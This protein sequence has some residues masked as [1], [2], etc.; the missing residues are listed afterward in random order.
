MCSSDLMAADKIVAQPS[1]ITGS[2]GVYGGKMVTSDL[3]KKLGITFD[4]VQRGEH[5]DMWS[6]VEPFDEDEWAKFNQWL[7]RVYVDFTTKAAEGRRMKLERLQ[8]LAKGRVW[9]GLDAKRHGLVDEL[10]G[11]P[12]ALRLARQAAHL[13]PDA[14][15]EVR[16]YPRPRNA[17]EE[18]FEQD[19]DNSEEE[20]AHAVR[21]LAALQPLL[22]AL[23]DAGVL[24]EEP[25]PQVLRA[26]DVAV[27]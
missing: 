20:G 9:S 1:T 2:I 19:R 22:R 8:E 23:R 12:T 15:V 24:G 17:F 21:A 10:G 7:D 13:A 25:P 11:Y 18:I 5:A 14:D 27:R 26:P 3:W 16:E 6:T 4:S